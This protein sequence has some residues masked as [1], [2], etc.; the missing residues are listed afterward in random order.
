MTTAPAP[1]P[2]RAPD[3]S[4]LYRRRAVFALLV[5]ATMTAVIIALAR[6]LGA[7]GLGVLDLAMLALFSL[8][9]PWVIIG[10]W[11]ALI[12]LWLLR[13]SRDPVGRVNPLVHTPPPDGARRSRTAVVMPIY[14]EAPEQVFRH[15]DTVVRS[16]E[17]LGEDAHIE[18]FLLSDTRRAEI[19]V[20]E[21]ARFAAYRSR[22]ARPERLHYRRRADNVGHKAGNL[23]EFCE[24]QG[25]DFDYMVVL[26]ADSVMSGAAIQRL[27][28]AMDANPTLGILQTLVVGLPAYSPF[29]RI[30]QFGM[31]QGM[32]AYTLGSA[33]WQGDQ[34]PY[35]GHNAIV[36]LEPFREHCRLPRLPGRPP[37]GGEILSHDQVEAALMRR[38]GFEVRVLPVEDGSYEQ[39]PP[40]LP[41]FLKRDLRWC[42]GNMQ[43]TRLLTLPGLLPLG[44]VQLALAILMYVSA[45]CWLGFLL[46]G[47]TQ[48]LLGGGIDQN[49]NMLPALGLFA[50]MMTMSFTPKL[51]GILDLL[52]HRESRAA[53]GGGGRVLLGAGVE[54]L[55]S[56]LLGPVLAL[57]HSVFIGGL[58]LG[59]Q[60]I[61]EAQ[62]RSSHSVPLGEAFRGLWLHT[63]LG[64]LAATLL[65]TTV[66]D[67]LPWAAPV[68][69]GLLLAAPLA[70]LSSLPAPGRWLAALRVC[71]VPEE[72]RT[73]T[74]VARLHLE[75]ERWEDPV[76]EPNSG[77]PKP[78]RA[79]DS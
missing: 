67:L 57:T 30:F 62:N 48:V 71:A 20:E 46:L 74:E 72:F 35:W 79:G 12:G 77:I 9:T 24:N 3:A 44:R 78:I 2:A 22:H 69:L 45:P 49:A 70:T 60:V 6:I 42:Q 40:T 26:D 5:L 37:L 25:G 32:R 73:P 10:F 53:Y 4:R 19:H 16:V 41:D 59:K 75:S 54:L 56:L 36:R 55:F 38:A 51:A 33:W 29:A 13:A 31:R 7:D 18:F 27:I 68:L 63:L 52:L 43:Y 8:T 76:E 58:L 17:A 66:P 64:L 28:R 23:R 39:N 50:V 15:L 47:F 1:T 65:A 34:G 11:N 61:W 14:N 21:E